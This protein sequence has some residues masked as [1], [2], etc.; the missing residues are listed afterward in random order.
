[1]SENTQSET[2]LQCPFCGCG[3]SL[4]AAGAGSVFRDGPAYRVECDGECHGMTC[5]WH[6]I[7][8]AVRAWNRRVI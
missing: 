1:M 7:Q 2:L 5:W 3:A 4:S 8:E 6:L